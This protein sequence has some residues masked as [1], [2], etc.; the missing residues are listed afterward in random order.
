M[1]CQHI[2]ACLHGITHSGRSRGLCSRYLRLRSSRSV[3]GSLSCKTW[4]AGMWSYFTCLPA[5]GVR[6]G[7]GLMLMLVTLVKS[8][9]VL[10]YHHEGCEHLVFLVDDRCCLFVLDHR[11]CRDHA[12]HHNRRHTCL[13][14]ADNSYERLVILP[15]V[16]L[17]DT[18]RFPLPDSLRNKPLF[19]RSAIS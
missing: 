19:S 4:P 13:S 15:A 6:L 7:R 10:T 11:S 17:I 2:V 16:L 5:L 14:W 3:L 12:S 8:C 1:F 18:N 9:F